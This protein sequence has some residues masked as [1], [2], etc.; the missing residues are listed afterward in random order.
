MARGPR[1]RQVHRMRLRRVYCEE[2][3]GGAGT[4]HGPE[5]PGM[6][7]DV[8]RRV[9]SWAVAG[10]MAASLAAGPAWASPGPGGSAALLA[11]V[12][13]GGSWGAL[14]EVPGTGALNAGGNARV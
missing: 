4:S 3:A 14:R 8:M 12:A 6:V 2:V 9:V 11:V 1:S 10:T 7:R 13:S 5:A